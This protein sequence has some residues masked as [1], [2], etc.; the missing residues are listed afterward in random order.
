MKWSEAKKKVFKFD[1]NTVVSAGAG[2]GKTA[3]LVELYLR[4]LS[5]ET[6]LE[7]P[8]AVDEIVAITFTEKAAAEMKERVR[9]GVRK[10]AEQ[11]DSK[12]DWEKI[13]RNLS[14]ANISTFHSFC[15]KILRENPVEAGI[16]PSFT[17][18]DDLSS[19]TELAAAVDQVLE[20]ELKTQSEE[21]RL[22]LDQF[23]LS[24]RGRGKGLREH[25]VDLHRVR[26]GSGNDI[27]DIILQVEQ[28]KSA[29]ERQFAGNTELL[30]SLIPEV[31]RILQGKEL[32]F[33]RK[34]RILP[35]MCKK[36]EISLQNM[37]M[38]A[39][40]C[41]MQSC[42]AGNWGK[43]KPLRDRLSECLTAIDHAFFQVRSSP[44]IYALLSLLEKLDLAYM[45]CKEGQGALDF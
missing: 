2:S 10:R 5:G 32:L 45:K 25:L 16:D 17:I 31:Q 21:I 43:E 12:V 22:L 14:S 6:A 33:H 24:G 36:N 19:K 40:L 7:Q 26:S 9:H 37:G 20:S 4:L 18:L 23:P 39:I 30:G 1:R 29:A 41:S 44:V 27:S 35:E 13:L 42:I 8:L 28:W 34:L 3:A 11:G 38:P 15:S